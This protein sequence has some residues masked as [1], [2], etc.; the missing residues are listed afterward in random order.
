MRKVW[1]DMNTELRC[2]SPRPLLTSSP[3]LIGIDVQAELCAKTASPNLGPTHVPQTLAQPPP[4]QRAIMNR[5]HQSRRSISSIA[6]KVEP[7]MGQLATP[8]QPPSVLSPKNRH[9]PPSHTNSPTSS[10]PTFGSQ[11]ALSPPASDVG[12]LRTPAAV[13]QHQ[14]SPVPGPGPISPPTARPVPVMAPTSAAANPRLATV[15]TASASV[16]PTTTPGT[17]TSPTAA[18]GYYTTPSFQNHIEQLGGFFPITAKF[19]SPPA[20]P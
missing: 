11:P 3:S 17:V 10:A 19:S 5:H 2:P 18:S 7:G 20:F 12:P 6:P 13:P 14:L 4:I 1:I 15:S 16:T 8:P 9:T